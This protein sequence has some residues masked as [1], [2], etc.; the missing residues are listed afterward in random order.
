[1]TFNYK[2]RG[3]T[4]VE[5][6]IVIVVIGIL[7]AITIVAYSGFQT[8]AENT[9]TIAGVNQVVKL[10]NLY[11]IQNGDYPSNGG[12]YYNCLG[13]GYPSGRCAWYGNGNNIATNSSTFDTALATVGTL[14]QLSTKSMMITTETYMGSFYEASN[15]RIRYY[16]NGASQT[17]GAGG[18]TVAYGNVTECNIYLE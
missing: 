16:L 17:C 13:S 6:L 14:P 5:L 18:S 9:K 3:F 15:K 12:T 7:A 11:K 2:Q 4:I 1:M 8:R 10:M